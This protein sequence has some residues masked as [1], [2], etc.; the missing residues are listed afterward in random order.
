MQAWGPALTAAKPAASGVVVD[1]CV[2]DLCR[3]RLRNSGPCRVAPSGFRF[4]FRQAD[5]GAG[6]RHH[7]IPISS[8]SGRETVNK[9]PTRTG[10][11]GILEDGPCVDMLVGA[12]LPDCARKWQHRVCTAAWGSTRWGPKPQCKKGAESGNTSGISPS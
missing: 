2:H 3:T 1:S 10:A 4:C 5:P 8:P 6:P 11:R 7:C 12:G 9:R